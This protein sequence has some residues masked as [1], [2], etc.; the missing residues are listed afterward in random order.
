MTKQARLLTIS[1]KVNQDEFD[2]IAKL[3][4]P[5]ELD[6]E[7]LRGYLLEQAYRGTIFDQLLREFL[8]MRKISIN[9]GQMATGVNQEAFRALVAEADAI[10]EDGPTPVEDDPQPWPTPLLEQIHDE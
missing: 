6:N 7:T 3:V 8:S 10:L 4:A 1:T 9:L 2:A 5:R